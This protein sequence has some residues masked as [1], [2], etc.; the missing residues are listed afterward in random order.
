MDD[1]VGLT[2]RMVTAA[3]AV[4]ASEADEDVHAYWDLVWEAVRGEGGPTALR[5]GLG[6][7]ASAD[8]VERKV[9][10]DLV[11]RTAE[12]HESVRGEVATALVAL[13]GAETAAA[14]LSSLVTALGRT[15]EAQAVPVLVRLVE[16]GD[17]EVRLHVAMAI[18]PV[19][20]G[21]PDGPDVRALVRLT[22]D[23][24]C[25]VRDW[26]T[27]SLGVCL[28]HDTT[29]IRDALWTRTADDYDDARG[30]AVHGLARR[31]DPRVVPLVARMLES[32]DGARSFAVDAA[33][34]LGAPELLPALRACEDSEDTFGLDRAVAA[35]D[36]VLR[37][38]ME[39][40]AWAVV[41]ELE[42]LRPG[43]GA[44]LSAPRFASVHCLEL[45]IREGAE[46]AYAAADLLARADGD[47]VR[48]AELVVADLVA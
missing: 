30:E 48:A 31:H 20:S 28:D 16:H 5:C 19:N 27:F 46:E 39:D 1:V 47:P 32:D 7:L 12:A 37:A 40:D 29:A 43:I 18:G 13:A 23:E 24:D 8:A 21:L 38:R 17:P 9:G 26:A 45:T 3:R 22:R 2:E 33:E 36:P 4:E 44:A 15:Q 35:C 14:V 6:L 34:V 42:R 25:E 11:G 10:C 41:V